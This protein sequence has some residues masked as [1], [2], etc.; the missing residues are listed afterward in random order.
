[1][2]HG[3]P[4][5]FLVVLTIKKLPII[6]CLVA[7]VISSTLHHYFLGVIQLCPFIAED[8]EAQKGQNNLLKVTQLI[9]SRL[10]VQKYTLAS[11]SMFST[12]THY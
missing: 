6:D 5:L 10:G 7:V 2:A 4:L 11:K 3:S 12:S 9:S 8:L 1:M